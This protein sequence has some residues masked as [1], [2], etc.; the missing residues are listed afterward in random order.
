MGGTD[1]KLVIVWL[2]FGCQRRNEKFGI[3]PAR[4][5]IVHPIIQTVSKRKLMNM[6]QYKNIDEYV[7]YWWIWCSTNKQK[8][9]IHPCNDQESVACCFKSTVFSPTKIVIYSMIGIFVI[10]TDL[11]RILILQI[12][13]GLM[14]LI[15]IWIWSLWSRTLPNVYKGDLGVLSEESFPWYAC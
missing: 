4:C 6:M 3:L 10:L 13:E 11:H 12:L 9:Q 15:N 8:L 7:E 5:Q 2:F 14:I 1:I